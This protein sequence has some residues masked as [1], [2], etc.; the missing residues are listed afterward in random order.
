MRHECQR[1]HRTATKNAPLHKVRRDGAIG[2]VGLLLL[3]ALL[4]LV[5]SNRLLHLNLLVVPLLVKE[6]G[7]TRKGRGRDGM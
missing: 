6:L 4:L 1:F 2:H 7:A 3:L 5:H